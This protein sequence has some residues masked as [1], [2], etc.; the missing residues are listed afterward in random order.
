M[1]N[2]S[3]RKSIEKSKNAPEEKR[4][5]GQAKNLHNKDQHVYNFVQ[6]QLKLQIQGTFYK[7]L[8][9]VFRIFNIQQN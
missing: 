2:E 5:N 4:K 1:K 7:K 6:E 8:W 3:I 9:H